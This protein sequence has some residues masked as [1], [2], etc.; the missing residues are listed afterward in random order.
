MKNLFFYFKIFFLSRAKNVK[1]GLL[2]LI[3]VIH[4]CYIAIRQHKGNCFSWAYSRIFQEHFSAT[5]G[6]RRTIAGLQNYGTGIYVFAFPCKADIAKATENLQM[7]LINLQCDTNLNQKFSETKLQDFYSY[8]PK[9]VFPLLRS[10]GLRMIA[11]FGSM[12]V[13]EQ[14]FSLVNN[15][16]TKSRS[17]LTDGHMK[18]VM[19]VVSSNIS[20]RIKILSQTKRCRLQPIYTVAKVRFD[21]LVV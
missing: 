11:M 20:P 9:E 8:L 4:S 17:G 10:F 7:E 16:K 3:L 14:F 2:P 6:A 12:Y 5:R 19:T 21:Q 15:I 13:C 1:E 18:S